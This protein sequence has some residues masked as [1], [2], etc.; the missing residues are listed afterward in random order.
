[1]GLERRRHAR[2]AALYPVEI[3]AEDETLEHGELQDLSVSGCGVRLGRSLPPDL[4]VR[5]R[6]D[7]GGVGLRF[8]GRIAWSKPG[9]S[10]AVHG[11]LIEG[12]TSDADAVFH[13]IF[14]LRLA[15]SRTGLS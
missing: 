9:P 12:F 8:H 3:R 10:A 1:M 4:P 14:L 6:C 15:E 2:F 11:I 7:I 13:Q 5:L